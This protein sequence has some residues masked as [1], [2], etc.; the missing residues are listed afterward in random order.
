ML[1]IIAAGAI[2]AGGWLAVAPG[3]ALADAAG[4]TDFKSEVVS[5]EPTTPEI[6][7]Q[8]IGGDSFVELTVQPGTDVIVGGYNNEP[9]LWFRPDGVVLE[10]QNSPATYLN[11]NRTTSDMSAPPAGLDPDAAPDWEQIASGH[12]WAW[13]DHRAHWMQSTDPVGASPGD[14][15][16][17]GVI[18]LVVDG[19]DVDVTVVTRWQPG[20]SPIPAMIGGVAGLAWVGAAA[21]SSRRRWPITPWLLPPAVL[22]LVVGL[23]Q[24][25]SLP[26][27]TGPRSIWWMLPAIAVTCAIGG[28]MAEFARAR[29]WPDAAVL[30]V[31]VELVVWGWVKRDGLSASLIP[32]DAP[33]WLDRFAVGVA[34]ATGVGF[35]ALAL[36]LL[37]LPAQLRAAPVRGAGDGGGPGAAAEPDDV[38]ES[39]AV[40]D[41][42]RPAHR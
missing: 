14:E 38:S 21:W 27:A 40:T 3:V 19:E 13:H 22:A 34:L 30:V 42:P 10:N 24:Y 26:A 15:V 29:F 33:G 6:D 31:G 1:K 2:V 37:F 28:M 4:P 5:I 11:E 16:L 35:V 7:V 23:W 39:T 32:T 9:Y 25:L 18:P 17:E 8:I 12:R 36:W 41:S 20:A